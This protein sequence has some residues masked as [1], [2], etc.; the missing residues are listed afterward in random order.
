M[1]HTAKG[2]WYNPNVTAERAFLASAA[3]TTSGQSSA[4]DVEDAAA[5]EGKVT[6]SAV[7]GT[8]PTLDLSLETTVDGTNW[9]ACGAF[10][11]KSGAGSDARMFAPLGQ[12]ARWKWAIGGSAGQSVTFTVVSKAHR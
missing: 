5:L 1:P 10:T 12:Q 2:Q 8:A 7:A 6:V 4:F 9:Y 11:Q 3:R